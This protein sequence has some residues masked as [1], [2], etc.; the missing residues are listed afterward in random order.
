[1]IKRNKKIMS[2]DKII[3]FVYVIFFIL[4]LIYSLFFPSPR[5]SIVWEKFSPDFYCYYELYNPRITDLDKETK[6]WLRVQIMRCDEM[7]LIR[8]KTD[9]YNIFAG[10]IMFI[11][12]SLCLTIVWFTRKY[13]VCLV[14][15]LERGLKTIFKKI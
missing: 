14:F 6:R 2:K 5:K 9:N 11:L 8:V 10:S 7:P 1:M 15:Y 12:F 3:R 4:I 13:A